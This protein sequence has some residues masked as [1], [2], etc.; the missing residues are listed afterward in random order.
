MDCVSAAI[1]HFSSFMLRSVLT[2]MAS[3]S[4]SDCRRDGGELVRAQVQVRAH[5]ICM[6]ATSNTARARRSRQ[7]WTPARAGGGGGTSCVPSSGCAECSRIMDLSCRVRSAKS[8]TNA[9]V[10]G[11]GCEGALVNACARVYHGC[12]PG[13]NSA[14]R[15]C[16]VSTKPVAYVTWKLAPCDADAM[17]SFE[18]AGTRGTKNIFEN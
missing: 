11:D 2:R 15:A 9:C 16:A 18:L 6:G 12:M 1:L 8:S 10:R 13:N 17:V 7:P 3:I 14:G 4:S 5:R